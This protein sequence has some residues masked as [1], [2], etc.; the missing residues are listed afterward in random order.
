MICYCSCA[1]YWQ[2]SQIRSLC[3]NL[4]T[5]VALQGQFDWN[6]RLLNCSRR[7]LASLQH[8]WSRPSLPQPQYDLAAC[9]TAVGNTSMADWKLE[10]YN[11][12]NLDSS[13]GHSCV[14]SIDEWDPLSRGIIWEW[15]C[16]CCE[17]VRLLVVCVI[18]VQFQSSPPI[19]R[20]ASVQNWVTTPWKG[21][22]R[23]CMLWC[24]AIR[25]SGTKC[26]EDRPVPLVVLCLWSH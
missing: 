25:H 13:V 1:F 21:I 20:M 17:H 5:Q 7:R 14:L 26:L 18:P 15:V 6:E 22:H 10:A 2:K 12:E 4:N 3:W 8:R 19:K 23:A 11:C 9:R 24:G 16:R